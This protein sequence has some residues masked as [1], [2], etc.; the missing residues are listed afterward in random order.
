GKNHVQPPR[1]NKI[2]Q[3]KKNEEKKVESELRVSMTEMM[4]FFQ[5]ETTVFARIIDQ[6]H[7]FPVLEN[8]GNILKEN[9]KQ[10]DLIKVIPLKKK[11]KKINK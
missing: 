3:Q 9:K 8:N 10:K 7:Y 6:L 4:A 11:K 1:Q 5:Q 2:N